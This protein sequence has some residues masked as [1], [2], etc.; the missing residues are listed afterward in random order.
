MRISEKER[1]PLAAIVPFLFL[2]SCATYNTGSHFDP[3]TNFGSYESFAWIGEDPYI[4]G[5]TSVLVSP[6][7]VVT[8]V[9]C[10]T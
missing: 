1:L 10:P 8:L 9:P 6:L 5:D 4:V 3:T 2:A 7:A